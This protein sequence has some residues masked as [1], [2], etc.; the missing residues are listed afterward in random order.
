MTPLSATDLFIVGGGPAGLAAALAARRL[1]LEV[2][3]ADCSQPP[4]DK[5]CGEGIMP[6]G[7]RAARSL[8]LALEDAGPRSF[9]G[10]RFAEGAESVAARFPTGR[11]FGLRRTALHQFLVDHAYQAGVRTALGR[12]RNLSGKCRSVGGQSSG[13]RALDRRRRRRQLRR[14]ALGRPCRQ[15]RATAGAIGFAAITGRALERVH[16]NPLGRRLPA[17]PDSGGD[18]EVCAVAISRDPHLRLDAG[19]PAFRAA[20]PSGIGPRRLLPSA[21]GFRP[22]GASSAYGEAMWR[23][24]ATPPVRSMPLPAKVCAC[25]SS[26]RLRWPRLW[27][28]KTFRSMKLP[29]AGWDGGPN[30]WRDLMLTLDRFPARPPADLPGYGARPPPVRPHAGH[31]RGRAFRFRLCRQRPFPRLGDVP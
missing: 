17:L 5:A 22:P 7:V 4:L 13:A 9:A 1:G 30:G 19:L 11:G 23:W 26:R 21:V 10:I 28:A 25:S 14:A 2:T 15:S 18:G 29:T 8:G 24:S 16:G 31:A 12:A 20:A 6:D 27:P 3:V